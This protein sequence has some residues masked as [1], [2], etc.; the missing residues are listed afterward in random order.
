MGTHVLH[1]ALVLLFQHLLHGA[2]DD[3]GHLV[4]VLRLD[5]RLQFILCSKGQGGKKSR[6]RYTKHGGKGGAP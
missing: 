3:L 6:K 1:F 5:H 2:F 4:H